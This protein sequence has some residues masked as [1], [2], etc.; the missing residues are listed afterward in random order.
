MD[1]FPQTVH[2]EVVLPTVLL[3]LGV[4]KCLLLR[5]LSI[6]AVDHTSENQDMEFEPI[7]SFPKKAFPAF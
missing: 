1:S 2:V 6:L 3:L 4:L 7:G 5:P